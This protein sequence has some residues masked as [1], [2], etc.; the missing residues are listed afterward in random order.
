M[1][2]IGLSTT[3]LMHIKSRNVATH[4]AHIGL[5]LCTLGMV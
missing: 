3:P 1:C 4:N 5:R 2:C